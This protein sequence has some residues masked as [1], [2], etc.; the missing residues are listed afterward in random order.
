MG[1]HYDFYENPP[2]EGSN[3]KPRLHARIVPLGT[4][5]TSEIAGF[6]HDM[7]TL[8]TGDVNAVLTLFREQL[9]DQLSMG[10]RVHWEGVGSFEL[11]L[12]SP[13]VHSP[14][15]IRA[16]SVYPKTI[17]FRPEKSLKKEFRFLPLTRAKEK[18]HS[19]RCSEVEI[20]GLLT[21]HF[22]NNPFITSSE[23]RRLCGLTSSTA[24]RRL[25]KLIA[26]GKLRKTGHPRSP[27]YEPVSGHY[28]REGPEQMS[29]R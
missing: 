12:A 28:R 4:I 14:K 25:R 9:I 17:A 16:E 26:D 7:S 20:D 23:F 27:L 15:E 22:L 18:N 8:T 11:V 29:T 5:N 13:P 19:N 2:K 3:K 6:I 24:N 10:Y 21:G 1:L